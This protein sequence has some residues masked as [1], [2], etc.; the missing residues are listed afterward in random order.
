MHE[1][2]VVIPYYNGHRT[3]G[4]LLSTI[5]N[6][7]PVIVVNDVSDEPMPDHPRKNLTVLNLNKKGY[8]SGAVNAGIEACNTDVLVLNQDSFFENEDPFTTIANLRGEYAVIGEGIKGNH[9]AWPKGYVHGTFMFMRRDAIDKVGLLNAKHYPLWGSTCE[10]QLKACRAGFKAMPI[11]PI[12]GFRHL[13]NDQ[14]ER[15]GS[16]ITEI[17]RKEPQ[18][19]DW[20]IRVPPMISVIVPAYNY[21]RYLKSLVNSLIGGSTDLGEMP[22]QTFQSFEIIIVNDASTD[23]T[24]EI[25]NELA[26]P[27]K[28]IRY[29]RKSV[30]GGTAAANNTGIKNAFGRYITVLCADDMMEPDR[31]ERLYQ[32][33]LDHPDKFVYDDCIL[34]KSGK[35]MKGFAM[36]E[37]DFDKLIYKNHIH[38]GIM[39]R[40]DWVMKVGGYPEIFARG[41]EDWAMNVRLG[42]NGYC[43]KRIPYAGYLYRREQQNRTLR[44]TT[45]AHHQK[46]LSMIKSL[47]PE[48]YGKPEDRPMSCCGGRGRSRRNRSTSNTLRLPGATQGQKL[49]EYI[50]LNPGKETYYGNVTGTR[51]TYGAGPKDRVKA[52]FV[53]DIPAALDLFENGKPV[54]RRYNPP[55]P[56]PKPEPEP[57]PKPEPEPAPKPE[58]E[59]APKPEPEPAP[60]PES[61]DIT[62]IEKLESV[63]DVLEDNLPSIDPAD[64]SINEMKEE[65]KSGYSKNDIWLMIELE[66]EGK[67]RSGMIKLLKKYA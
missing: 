9:P 61:K 37:Y 13:R 42:V 34:F 39:V 27:W 23:E 2:T 45:P 65:L 18:N 53:E 25:A 40:R 29:I 54:F 24:H 47:H 46:F 48:A 3:I 4:R 16:S 7:V 64:Y 32:G 22:G 26:D 63:A 8:F 35:R 30:N 28:G 36:E 43:G 49:L 66:E 56:A 31:L 59:P 58:P 12:P 21:G 67:N 5:P 57:A 20:F 10:W 11:R 38:C 6:N 33:C 1:I 60:K 17:L 19:K 62:I 14:K 15:Y 44:N 51:Y 41:R 50:G 55:K 52:F